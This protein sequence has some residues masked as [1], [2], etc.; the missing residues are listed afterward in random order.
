[1]KYKPCLIIYCSWIS[2][3]FGL[4]LLN[5]FEVKACDEVSPKLRCDLNILSKMSWSKVRENYVKLTLNWFQQVPTIFVN[6]FVSSV[7]LWFMKTASCAIH[8]GEQ[9]SI[10]A[11]IIFIL[12]Q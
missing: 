6:R 10:T 11:S 4:W 2:M 8:Y 9:K 5:R 3:Q 7:T 12:L 1:M